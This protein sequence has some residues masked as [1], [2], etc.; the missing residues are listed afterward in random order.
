[1][2]Y[3]QAERGMNKESVK[4]PL[5]EF[6]EA[7]Y[8]TILDDTS[9]SAADYIP[10][11]AIVNPDKLGIALTTVDGVTYA[12][13]DCSVDFTIQSIS[14]AFVYSLAIERMGSDGVLKKIGVE[15][16]GEAF[17]SNGQFR[18]YKL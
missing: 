12:V 5:L 17:N 8:R 15:P 2:C 3:A 9:G 13:S 10:E 1:M 6:L 7:Q 16:S 18:C 14:K 4:P 11:L